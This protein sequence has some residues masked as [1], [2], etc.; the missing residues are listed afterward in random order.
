[1]GGESDSYGSSRKTDDDSY[2]SSGRTQ[3]TSYG[4]GATSGAGYGNKSSSYA[5][6]TSDYRG[7]EGMGDHDKPYSG[8]T[9]SYGSGTTGG[10]GYGNKTGSYGDD[11]ESS[12]K[13]STAG[14]L[15]EKVG[16]MFKNENLERKGAEKRSHAGR[17]EDE[18]NY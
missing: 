10:A 2:G 3:D 14:K 15:M 18:S 1:M 7:S 8:G 17:D 11:D 13:D 16:G 12:K 6:D 9:D 5:E 4:S